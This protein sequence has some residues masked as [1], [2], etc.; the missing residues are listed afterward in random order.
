MRC[1]GKGGLE[2]WGVDGAKVFANKVKVTKGDG[3][4]L[5]WVADFNVSMVDGVK[6]GGVGREAESANE[7]CKW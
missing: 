7:R 5:G 3:K 2:G 4:G 6:E 1:E